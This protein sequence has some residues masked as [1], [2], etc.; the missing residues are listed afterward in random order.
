MTDVGCLF[1]NFP[2]RYIQHVKHTCKIKVCG[3]RSSQTC[4]NQSFLHQHSVVW[5][6]SLLTMN[7]WRIINQRCR[8]DDTMVGK[9]TGSLNKAG[10]YLKMDP[11]YPVGPAQNS[12]LT[13]IQ[14]KTAVPQH[15]AAA[16]PHIPKRRHRREFLSWILDRNLLHHLKYDCKCPLAED[17]YRTK[18]CQ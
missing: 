13:K 7:L 17:I 16:E 15:P 18:W 1:L 4:S 10:T 9:L 12:K 3:R 8:P 6:V 14:P 11:L 5:K 2:C